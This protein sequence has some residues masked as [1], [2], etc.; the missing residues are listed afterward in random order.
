MSDGSVGRWFGRKH[1][2]VRLFNN[3]SEGKLLF[4]HARQN[5]IL[6]LIILFLIRGNTLP[7]RNPNWCSNHPHSRSKIAISEWQKSGGWN[8]V[9][10]EKDLLR[11]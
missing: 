9:R 2:L 6:F 1:L 8:K 11:T 3:E 4:T 7:T 10:R 5:Q